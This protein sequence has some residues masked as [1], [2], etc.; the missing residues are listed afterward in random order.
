MQLAVAY[1]V[2]EFQ[3]QVEGACIDSYT[4]DVANPGEPEGTL[5]PKSA[6]VCVAY[7]LKDSKV[8]AD[9]R[10]CVAYNLNNS[11]ARADGRPK[12]PN[13]IIRP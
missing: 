8:R 13:P 11:K 12:I 10:V 7:N 3:G 6:L 4:W 2:L 5:S 1:A 9:G